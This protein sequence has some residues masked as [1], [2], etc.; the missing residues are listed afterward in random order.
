MR[1]IDADELAKVIESMYA[2]GD[3]ST[4][5]HVDAE[6]DTLIGKFAVLDAIYD[7]ETIS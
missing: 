7:A 5:H 3:D 2:T 1:L 6:G 4:S